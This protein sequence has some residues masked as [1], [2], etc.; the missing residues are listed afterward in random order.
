MLNK[1]SDNDGDDG[2]DCADGNGGV[3]DDDDDFITSTTVMVII[4]T[5]L[6]HLTQEQRLQTGHIAFA[7]AA[8]E[9]AGI[10]PLGHLL[11]LSPRVRQ[12]LGP[13]GQQSLLEPLGVGAGQSA[14]HSLPSAAEKGGRVKSLYLG[15]PQHSVLSLSFLFAAQH[16]TSAGSRRVV[17]AGEARVQPELVDVIVRKV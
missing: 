8:R 1:C 16:A 13:A 17:Y 11:P 4:L 6:V 14:V 3:D 2:D 15:R 7:S 12:P 5:F 10:E 9:T